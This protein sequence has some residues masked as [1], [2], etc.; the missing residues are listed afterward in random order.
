METPDGQTGARSSYHCATS[1]GVGVEV[2]GMKDTAR[3]SGN[4]GGSNIQNHQTIARMAERTLVQTS[5]TGE[6]RRT[7]QL[8]QQR[9]DIG[10]PDALC[11]YLDSNLTSANAPAA[12]TLA[13]R[14]DNVLVQ[15]MHAGVR[16]AR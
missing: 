4:F 14:F 8:P 2:W 5:V 1:L 11:R 15:D 10:V 9:D 16:P 3:K 6:E 12:Q 13:L 7:A